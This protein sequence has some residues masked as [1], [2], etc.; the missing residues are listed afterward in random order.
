MTKDNQSIYE[1]MSRQRI[2]VASVQIDVLSHYDPDGKEKRMQELYDLSHK[3]IIDEQSERSLE[4]MDEL[5]KKYE[6]E[7]NLLRTEHPDTERSEDVRKKIRELE[8]L[9]NLY[10]L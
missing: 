8:R 6:W 1:Q 5:I 10:S 9:C 7:L 3:S 4:E 2:E